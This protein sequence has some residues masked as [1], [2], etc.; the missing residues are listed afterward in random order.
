[1]I[2]IA[3]YT[4]KKK[5]IKFFRK[6]SSLST[7]ILYEKNRHLIVIIL[8]SV[9]NW[10]TSASLCRAYKYRFSILLNSMFLFLM[11]GG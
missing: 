4:L 2:N 3:T 5:L 1:M 9:L 6:E 10:L 11:L 8:L 7:Q